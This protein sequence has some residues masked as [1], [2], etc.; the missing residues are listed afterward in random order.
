MRRN[1]SSLE[2]TE[3]GSCFNQ[4]ANAHQ[5]ALFIFLSTG[6]TGGVLQYSVISI[7]LPLK[8]CQMKAQKKKKPKEPE[9]ATARAFRFMDT[10][11]QK[12]VRATSITR[13]LQQVTGFCSNT[14]S[15]QKHIYC[16]TRHSFQNFEAYVLLFYEHSLCSAIFGG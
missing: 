6:R 5:C 16:C 1:L 2:R 8:G 10:S 3:K 7:V 4:R 11:P 13:A 15:L 12:Q 9:P 14:P